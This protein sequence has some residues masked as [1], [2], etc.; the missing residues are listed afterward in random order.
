[1]K[2]KVNIIAG[3]ASELSTIRWEQCILLNKCRAGGAYQEKGSNYPDGCT[4]LAGS[5]TSISTRKM[6]SVTQ[7]QREQHMKTAMG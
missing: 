5:R 3:Q 6:Q 1:V 2:G 4:L 7:A